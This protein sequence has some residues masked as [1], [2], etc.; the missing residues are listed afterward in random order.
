MQE[1][2]YIAHRTFAQPPLPA[3]SRRV[4]SWRSANAVVEEVTGG[5]YTLGYGFRYP[6]RFAVFLLETDDRSQRGYSIWRCDDGRPVKLERLIRV[7]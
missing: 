7:S 5:D 2:T 1:R 3:Q 4:R 6:R